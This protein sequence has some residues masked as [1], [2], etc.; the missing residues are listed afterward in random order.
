[1]KMR[2]PSFRFN[3]ASCAAALCCVHATA[4]CPRWEN[5]P[6]IFPDPS[7][8]GQVLAMT[9]WD[10]DGTGPA[11]PLLVIG[12]TFTSIGGIAA[13][14]IAAFNGFHWS[15][16]ESGCNNT[17]LALGVFN[18]QLI[19]GGDFTSAGGVSVNHIA[20]WNGSVWQNLGSG[21][22]G[23]SFSGRVSA[24]TV[25]NNELI[26][27]GGFTAAGGLAADCIARWNG[28]TWNILGSG[29]AMPGN[30][31]RVQCL[32]VFEGL[33][34]AGGLFTS[35]GGT[36][37]NNI[38]KW[39]GSAWSKLGLS[40]G[41]NGTDGLVRCFLIHDFEGT[42]GEQLVLGGSFSSVSIGSVTF[43]TPAVA[44][45]SGGTWGVLGPGIPG[46]TVGGLANDSFGFIAGG[47]F[48]GPFNSIAFWDDSQ[49][50]WEPLE[51]GIESGSVQCM[52]NYDHRFAGDHIMLGGAF[53]GVGGLDV[54]NLAEVNSVQLEFLPFDLGFFPFAFANVGSRL[55]AGGY[56]SQSANPNPIDNI[57][58]WDG[59]QLSPLGSGL[60]GYASAMA[61]RAESAS[62]TSLAVGGAF[63]IAGGLPANNVALW[64]ANSAT[65]TEGWSAM[66][67]GFN[68]EVSAMAVFRNQFVAGGFFTT[69]GGTTVN[70]IARWNGSAWTPFETGVTGQF[71]G[72]VFAFT[73]RTVGGLGDPQHQLIVGGNFTGAG[74]LSV[75]NVAGWF[76]NQNT[77]GDG[78]FA[79]GSGFNGL[80][81]ALTMHSG[82]I[83]AGGAFT[84]S[85]GNGGTPLNHV[86]RWTGTTWEQVGPGLPTSVGALLS[87]S[88]VLY[89]LMGGQNPALMKWEGATWTTIANGPQS[90]DGSSNLYAMS[91]YHNEIHA[92]G[93]FDSINSGTTVS[94]A[95]ARYLETG[96]PWIVNQPLSQQRPCGFN[97]HFPVVPAVGYNNLTYAWRR[98]G[99]PLT[100][101]AT[102]HGSTIIGAN[103]S[104]LSIFN[105]R[106]EDAGEY[107]CVISNEC[108]G[109]TS[110]LATLTIA[111]ACC[112]GDI[113]GDQMV[114][115]N[116]LLVVINFWGPCP[117]G[118]DADIAPPGG[119]SA[120]DINDLLAVI[121]GWGACP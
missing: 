105:L 92:G 107:D 109:E 58:A 36:S 63:S 118:C 65:S 39:N 69:S 35:A 8:N 9:S 86:A 33:L 66:G 62:I 7:P 2:T 108:G 82:S 55:I 50:Q 74:G 115:V 6:L 71:N 16:L 46:A 88:G 24:L 15:P 100:N 67:A 23:G 94:P 79:L 48:P 34:Y 61:V 29:M 44:R 12:G 10:V 103:S 77:H 73:T 30:T 112:T 80:V 54:N 17:V 38:A 96:A 121:N 98:D 22:V 45:W 32:T 113:T 53:Q 4:Q 43:N 3:I 116:D 21:T 25:F 99:I 117:L 78:W 52:L 76:E 5:G 87:K 119:D 95:W 20:R 97:A 106:N 60:N 51:G 72:R 75:N 70:G 91:A 37:A 85:G 90:A 19:A 110:A 56:G 40:F 114:N 120:I 49:A 68:N 102:A 42:L 47:F 59:V 11:E 18:G 31:P 41:G 89:A 111:P 27:G 14:R 1:M 93:V 81:F 84:L 101:G 28:A 26:V 13:N 64:T 104:V 83:Y 57:M